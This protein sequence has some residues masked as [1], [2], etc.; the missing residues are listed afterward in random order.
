MNDS[1]FVARLEESLK[2]GMSNLSEDDKVVP[3]IVLGGHN[4]FNNTISN[5]VV[6]QLNTTS[7]EIAEALEKTPESIQ[8]KILEAILNILEKKH[9]ED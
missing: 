9:S 3:N 4:V 6:V 5:S 7:E 2:K 8:K 1:S